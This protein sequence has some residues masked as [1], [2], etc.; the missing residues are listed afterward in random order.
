MLRMA[1]EM[2]VNVQIYIKNQLKMWKE[3]TNMV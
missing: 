3:Q 1:Y 2:L